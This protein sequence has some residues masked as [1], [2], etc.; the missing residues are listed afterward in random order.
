MNRRIKRWGL[1]LA[2]AVVLPAAAAAWYFQPYEAD[3]AAIRAMRDG[4][5]VSVAKKHGL[6]VFEGSEV[7]PPVIIL[8]P[9]GLIA[10]ESYAPLARALAASGRRTVIV[11][12]PF[13][14][15]GAGVDRADRVLAAY[16]GEAF[17]IGGHSLGGTMAARY[18]A[19]HPGQ[20]SGLFLL[21]AYPDKQ[22]N[23]RH[24]NLPVLS[25]IGSRDGIVDREKW[26]QAAPFLPADTAYI[27]IEG[28]N[29]TQ[30]GSYGPQRGDSPAA[31]LPH[32]QWQ[33]T[34]SILDGWLRRLPR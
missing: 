16:P 5:G 3:S 34:A 4:E 14:L 23:V 1:V 6:I 29:H 21:A 2:A 25:L 13:Y 8:Y 9:G 33:Q 19:S 11:K 18:A 24:A 12:M 32:D 28:G 15:A 20:V 22:G 17:V 27:T 26:E 10:P 31:I 30:F 7:R